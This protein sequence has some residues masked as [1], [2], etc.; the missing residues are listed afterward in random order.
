LEKADSA[1]GA[2]KRLKT[3]L[4]SEEQMQ[5]LPI[6]AM[7]V[8][9]TLPLTRVWKKLGASA[10]MNDWK[11]HLLF[12]SEPQEADQAEMM[13]RTV[14]IAHHTLHFATEVFAI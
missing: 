5:E 6:G 12:I 9:M 8:C 10:L 11:V 14:S 3:L 2:Y 1:F 4:L 7:S 13:M